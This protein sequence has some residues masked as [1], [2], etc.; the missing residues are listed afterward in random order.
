MRLIIAN[1]APIQD[2]CPTDVST[3]EIKTSPC[4]LTIGLLFCYFLAAFP[5]LKVSSHV[6]GIKHMF[7][8]VIRGVLGLRMLA[9]LTSHSGQ[10]SAFE[11]RGLPKI[12]KNHKDGLPDLLGPLI[13][14]HYSYRDYMHF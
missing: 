4:G 6:Y 13:C 1:G 7:T 11:N 9:N 5:S 12:G 2:D 14:T 8:Y 3:K 10:L